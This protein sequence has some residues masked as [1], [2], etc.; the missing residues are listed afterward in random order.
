MTPVVIALGC[1]KWYGAVLGVSDVSG[2]ASRPASAARAEAIAQPATS[3]RMN[4]M[5]IG[6][7]LPAGAKTVE[8][9]FT[10]PAFERGKMIT[11][12]AIIIALVMTGIGLIPIGGPGSGKRNAAEDAIAVRRAA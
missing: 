9:T 4:L 5:L 6:V 11:M 12:T 1:S 7:P 3:E 10:S 2:A 8:L